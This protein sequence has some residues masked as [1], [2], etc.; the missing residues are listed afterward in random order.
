MSSW[1]GSSNT[2]LSGTSTTSGCSLSLVAE[3]VVVLLEVD[4]LLLA[5]TCSW[6]LLLL[7]GRLLPVCLGVVALLGVVMVL[8]VAGSWVC[9]SVAVLR[10]KVVLGIQ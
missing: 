2:S 6:L 10:D 5:F 4:E 3:L 8:G 1:L 9:L 7:P